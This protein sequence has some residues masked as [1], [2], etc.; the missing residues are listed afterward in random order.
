VSGG[1]SVLLLF[2]LGPS[3][4]PAPAQGT[5]AAGFQPEAADGR[6]AGTASPG[7]RIG[8]GD[9]LQISVYGHEEL[10]GTSVVQPG[11]SFP[12]P[13]IG[14]VAAA[15][16]TTQEVESRIAKQLA[17]GFVRDAQVSVVVRDYRSKV[18]YVVGDVAR[19]G[20]YP[21][22]GETRIVEILSRAGPLQTA[23]SEVLIVRPVE[24]G[25]R[26]VLPAEVTRRPGAAGAPG[27]A[28]N[29]RVLRVN[30]RAI[31]RGQLSENVALEANDTVFVPPAEQIFVTGEVRN[32]GAF[33]YREG[34]TARQ[35]VALAGGFGEN[36]SKGGAQVVRETAGKVRTQKVKLDEQ[37]QP[38]DTVVI[39]KAW[40]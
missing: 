38:G 35:A 27:A 34:I 24:H 32:P 12:F 2:L 37:L 40:F 21:L 10:A 15:G 18:V 8:P 20:T 26:P 9:V 13:L 28:A 25:G 22:A 33:T 31:Q 16:A 19:P 1:A 4:A 39:K 30:V 29:A 5:P 11:G 6:P 3:Q 36:A 7:Y 14:Q 23:G 17:K